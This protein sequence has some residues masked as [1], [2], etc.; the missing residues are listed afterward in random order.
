MD[1][2]AV[3]TIFAPGRLGL[4]AVLAPTATPTCGRQ[5]QALNYRQESVSVATC[6]Y[7][8]GDGGRTFFKTPFE[9]ELYS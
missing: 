8:G 4:E 5:T 2:G 3:S 1:I 9:C 7:I 6:G